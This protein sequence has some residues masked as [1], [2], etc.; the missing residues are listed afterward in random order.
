MKLKEIK[1]SLAKWDKLIH[2]KSDHFKK[3]QNLISDVRYFKFKIKYS[4]KTK[5]IHAYPGIDDGKLKLFLIADEYDKKEYQ[6][7]L[8][9]YL[10]VSDVVTADQVPSLGDTIQRDE[11]LKRIQNWNKDCKKWIP[12]QAAS[13]TGFLKCYL[14]PIDDINQN[15]DCASLAYFALKNEDNKIGFA[16]DLILKDD[17]DSSLEGAS[18]FYDTVKLVPPFSP[19]EEM[20]L[21]SITE[22][23]ALD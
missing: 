9:N 17:D 14:I 23:N 20:Y 19:I 7:Q 10:Q 8:E 12:E 13:P 2:D 5:F 22:S 16:A 18:E 21:L 3:L 11:A 6:D 1:R 15:N 4:D